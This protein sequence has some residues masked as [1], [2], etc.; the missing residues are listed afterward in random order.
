LAFDCRHLLIW[1][2]KDAGM[3]RIL[4]L[5]FGIG[6]AAS[7]RQRRRT[8]MMR[9]KY[10][11]AASALALIGTWQL[12]APA[13]SAEDPHHPTPEAAQAS[14]QTPPATPPGMAGQ[15]GMMSGPMMNM[16]SMMNMMQMMGGGY[17]PGMGMIDHVEG[18]ISFL[19]TELKITDAQ[20]GVWNNFATALRANAQ[21]LGTA[22][23]AMMGQMR[24]GQQQGQT[25]AERLDAQ[26]R[27][28]AA[29]LDGTRAI[30]A[31]FTKLYEA[32]S[33]DQK[34]AADELLAPHM[35]M[36]MMMGVGAQM[37]R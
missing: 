5:K 29:R 15:L 30:K 14:P 36:R 35:G 21:T 3:G 10:L 2:N 6:E 18:R 24:T 12:S 28:F 31:A 9:L 19:R 16:M 32:L 20:A 23:G 7:T 27:W 1:L 25:L 26:E 22:R 13:Q 11:V 34:K 8:T 33:Q 17:A 4:H 37:A